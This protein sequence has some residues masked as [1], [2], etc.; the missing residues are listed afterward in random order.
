MCV[1]GGSKI[2]DWVSVNI[3]ETLSCVYKVEE[4]PTQINCSRKV[5]TLSCVYK[6]E[7]STC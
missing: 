2:F 1:Q 4:A 3:A 5:V 7:E 6:V